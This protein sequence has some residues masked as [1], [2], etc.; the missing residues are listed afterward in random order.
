MKEPD[1]NLGEENKNEEND[2]DPDE[3]YYNYD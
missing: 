2:P 1:E 3:L